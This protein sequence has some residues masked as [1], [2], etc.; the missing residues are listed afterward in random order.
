MRAKAKGGIIAGDVLGQKLAAYT[1]AF[2]STCYEWLPLGLN[3][4]ICIVSGYDS[5]ISCRYVA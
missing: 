1:F 3:K 2:C 4:K 5:E